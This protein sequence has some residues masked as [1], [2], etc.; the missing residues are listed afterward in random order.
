MRSIEGNIY[1]LY[2]APSTKVK[3][4]LISKFNVIPYQYINSLQEKFCKIND[5]LKSWRLLLSH[6]APHLFKNR[7]YKNLKKRK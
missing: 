3:C 7:K 1:S 2:E 6:C 5:Q 4:E